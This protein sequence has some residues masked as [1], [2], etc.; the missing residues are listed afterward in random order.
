MQKGAEKEEKQ[1]T[2]EDAPT[3][4]AKEPQKLKSESSEQPKPNGASAIDTLSAVALG[5]LAIFMSN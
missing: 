4:D 1:V 2:G 5:A 3:E